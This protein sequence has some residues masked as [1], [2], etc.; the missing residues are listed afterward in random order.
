MFTYWLEAAPFS[1][2][3]LKLL[4]QCWMWVPKIL[5]WK[6]WLERNN[7]IFR[8]TV[9]SP[10]QVALKVKALLGDLAAS[11]SN[12]KNEANADKDDYNWFHN[13]DPSLLSR[14]KNST[15]KHTPWEI[16]LGELEFIK[17]RS[18]LEKHVLHVDGASKGNP[19]NSGSG[20]VIFDSSGKIVLKFAWGLGHNTNNIAEI[21]AIWQGL[22]QARR[23]SI[24]HVIVIGDSS[25]IIQAFNLNKAP[26]NMVLVHYF[27]KFLNLL[28]DFDEIKFY[29]VLRTLNQGADHEANIG[30][31]LNRGALLVNSTEHHE[32]IP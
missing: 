22:C 26:K 11:N 30:T 5:C 20:G 13:L 16:R 31:S 3:K 29:H 10:P 2:T 28:K 9:R 12:I 7:R 18:S 14:I 1:F 25:I 4:K 6:L 21:L 32:P 24:K 27:R 15:K 17:W 19:G 23:L 8:D